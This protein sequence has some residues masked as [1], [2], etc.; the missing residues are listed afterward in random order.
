MG[1][2]RQRVVCASQPLI[3]GDSLG[4]KLEGAQSVWLLLQRVSGSDSPTCKRGCTALHKVHHTLKPRFVYLP[5]SYCL[6]TSDGGRGSGS[7]PPNEV[8]ALARLGSPLFLR[9]LFGRMGLLVIHTRTRWW[10]EL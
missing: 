5:S 3:R 2:L 9:S 7:L 1:C 6:P 8:A 10:I 4:A